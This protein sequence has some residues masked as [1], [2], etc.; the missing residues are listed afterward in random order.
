MTKYKKDAN[1]NYI[2][3]GHK[4]EILE[5]SRAQVMHGT[6]YKT[7]GGLTKNDL[8]QNKNGRI[9]SK[10]KHNVAKKEKRLIKAGYGTK[11]GQF[12]AVRLSSHRSSTRHTKIRR[13]M[14]K[15]LSKK[16]GRNS[17]RGGNSSVVAYNNFGVPSENFR[18]VPSNVTNMSNTT[19]YN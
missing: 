9:V 14:M 10:K 11:K 17:M 7:S 12:G 4:Y 18:S 16:R 2:I 15:N 3:H 19:T 6:A 1:G 5:G 13:H 8:T